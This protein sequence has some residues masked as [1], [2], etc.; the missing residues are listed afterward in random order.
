MDEVTRTG[1]AAPATSKQLGPY[2]IE[3]RLGEGG[4][5]EVFRATDTRLRRTVAVKLLLGQGPTD[6]IRRERFEREAHAASALNHPNICTVYD[7]GEADGRPYLVMECLDGETLRARLTRGPLP[8]DELLDIAIQIADALA[9]AHAAGII[10]R[11]LKPA[12]IFLTTRGLAKVMDFGIAKRIGLDAG[13][14][15]GTIAQPS[16]LTELGA[17]IG[18]V[19]YMSPEQARGEPLDPRTDLFSLG[20]VLY[21]MATGERPFSGGTDAVVFDALLNRDAPAIRERRADAPAGL[22]TLVARLLAKHRDG[23]PRDAAELLAE[24]KLLRGQSGPVHA[25]VEPGGRPRRANTQRVRFALIALVVLAAGAIAYW[26][27]PRQGVAPIRSLAVLPFDNQIDAGANDMVLGLADAVAADLA[28]SPTVGIVPLAVA[29]TY[30]G[31]TKSAPEIARELKADALVN[32]VLSR[33]GD[34]IRLAVNV[35]SAAD[36]RPVWSDTYQRNANELVGLQRAVADGVSR[37]IGTTL[38]NPSPTA[39]PNASAVNPEA[40]DLYLRARY[41]AGRVNEPDLDQAI[42]LLEKATELD[43]RFTLGQAL[44]GYVYGDKSFNYRPADPQLREKGYAAVEK[45]LAGD[46]MSP[47]A[48]V[49]RGKL[50]WQPSESFPSREALAEYRQALAVRPTFDDAW[51]QRGV[52]LFH[53]GHLEAGLRAVERAAELNPANT[54][55]RFRVAPIRVY[56]QRYEDAIAALRRV[57][58]EVYPPQW[59]Y[60]MAWSLISLGR[61]DEASQEIET[62]LSGKAPDQGGVVHAARAMLRLKR[63]DRPGAE[64]DIAEAIERGKGFGHFHHTAYSIGAI[65]AQL[66]EFDRAQEWIER[67]AADGFPCYSMFE[68]DPYLT[69]LRDTAR[70]RTFLTKLRQEWE[71]IPGEE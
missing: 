1:S 25:A 38:P 10:H 66:G 39:T 7:V 24:L 8:F 50:L 68:T 32:G 6:P 63:G 47:E 58:R 62:A 71:S 45:A 21:E 46:P 40:Y 41:H 30:R 22:D 65:Y 59:T 44:L 27:L 56:Q 61:L 14:N 31:S 15:D 3:G 60:Q 57:P 2:R 48:H 35:L 52:V 33:T 70:F 67:A 5:G 17:P 4:M 49:A 11:D 12:N 43:P 53:V 16:S 23:R 13:P 55:A 18:T 26:A 34:Q 64:A 29:A 36:G 51:H 9:A 28:R 20:V 54:Q 37:A 42:T 69:K 19:A